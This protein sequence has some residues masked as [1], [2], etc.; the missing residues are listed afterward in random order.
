MLYVVIEVYG[1][2]LEVENLHGYKLEIEIVIRG[3]TF[4]I[5]CLCITM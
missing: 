1:K 4:M 2:T 3:K 5:A